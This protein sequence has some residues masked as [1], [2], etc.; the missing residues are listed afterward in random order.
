MKS[1][2]KTIADQLEPQIKRT[3]MELRMKIADAA[4]YFPHCPNQPYSVVWDG[5]TFYS[6]DTRELV[7]QVIAWLKK[8]IEERAQE[9]HDRLDTYVED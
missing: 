9:I 7:D 8:P 2:L 1:E 5:Q 3:S 6:D 4:R